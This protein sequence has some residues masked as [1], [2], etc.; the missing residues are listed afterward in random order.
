MV[1]VGM[2]YMI[3]EGKEDAFETVF[4]KVLAIMEAMEGHKDSKLFHEVRDPQHYLIVS[5]WHT[6]DAFEAFTQSDKF[7]SVVNWGKEQVLA[8]RPHHEIY[9]GGDKPAEA[10]CPVPH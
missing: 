4:Y 8:T 2:N 5:E 9:G 3:L 10:G 6:Q 1:T 7:K